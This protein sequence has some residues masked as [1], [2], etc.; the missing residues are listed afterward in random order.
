M[1]NQPS[2]TEVKTA[3]NFFM[4]QLLDQ[5]NHRWSQNA[6]ESLTWIKDTIEAG[7]LDKSCDKEVRSAFYFAIETK[8]QNVNAAALLMAS[9]AIE[10]RIITVL[11][12]KEH[13]ILNTRFEFFSRSDSIR[14]RNAAETFVAAARQSD[15][16]LSAA[17]AD[18]LKLKELP[19][20]KHDNTPRNSRR[21]YI[22]SKYFRF[23]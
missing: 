7:L 11:E 6:E 8:D 2:V 18:K 19:L 20:H 22:T 23:I 21:R 12:P 13:Q 1:K 15:R 5:D 17:A 14:T 10:A 4:T 9:V 16:M 3:F